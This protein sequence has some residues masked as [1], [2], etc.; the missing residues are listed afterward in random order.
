MTYQLLDVVPKV[1]DVA[2]VQGPA[3][4]ASQALLAELAKREKA[5][6]Q[7][8]QLE[9]LNPT[10]HH[11]GLCVGVS[12]QVA[13]FCIP[14]PPGLGAAL[15]LW[16]PLD[17]IVTCNGFFKWASPHLPIAK[18][19]SPLVPPLE[20]GIQYVFKLSVYSWKTL[21]EDMFNVDTLARAYAARFA[22]IKPG[23]AMLTENEAPVLRPLQPRPGRGKGEDNTPTPD[24]C[25]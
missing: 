8:F 20:V 10:Q 23:K 4:E 16:A 21:A 13:V 5:V 17:R 11:V 12:G 24:L 22:G 7:P 14:P 9:R 3:D 15:Y 6:G 25:P 19:I 18:H 2:L 1:A